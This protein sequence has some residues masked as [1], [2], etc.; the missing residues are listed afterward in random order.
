MASS[1]PT[2]P[3]GTTN[4]EI[5]KDNMISMLSKLFLDHP[6]T[7]VAIVFFHQSITEV[8]QWNQYDSNTLLSV[9]HQKDLPHGTTS[10]LNTH[11]AMQ[12]MTALFRNKPSNRRNARNVCLLIQSDSPQS[13]ISQIGYEARREEISIFTIGLTNRVDINIFQQL[14]TNSQQPATTWIVADFVSFT[15]S[16]NQIY[17]VI[18]NGGVITPI[19]VPDPRPQPNPEPDQPLICKCMNS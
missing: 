1:Y 9:V 15:R 16:H 2:N 13:D 5:V 3:P 10:S 11:D 19:P 18:F 14:S 4:W 8:I 17:D 12:Q 6:Y 7:N